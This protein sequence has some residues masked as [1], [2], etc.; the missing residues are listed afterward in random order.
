MPSF[1]IV[2]QRPPVTMQQH[3]SNPDFELPESALMRVP[4]RETASRLTPQFRLMRFFSC[5]AT[6]GD[7]ADTTTSASVVFAAWVKAFC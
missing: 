3:V 1:T 4:E 5:L 7:S 6:I 2:V